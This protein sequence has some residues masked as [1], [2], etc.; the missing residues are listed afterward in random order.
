M[1]ITGPAINPAVAEDRFT[2]G[3]GQVP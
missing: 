1:T 3:S 2:A